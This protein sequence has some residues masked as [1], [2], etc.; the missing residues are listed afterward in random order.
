MFYW[1][2]IA[3]GKIYLNFLSKSGRKSENSSLTGKKHK[4]HFF[5]FGIELKLLVISK[6]AKILDFPN[7]N[8]GNKTEF[9]MGLCSCYRWK[10][11]SLSTDDSKIIKCESQLLKMELTTDQWN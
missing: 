4:L 6:S 2:L 5:S 9:H 3:N 1:M 8:W 11:V 7:N 10:L